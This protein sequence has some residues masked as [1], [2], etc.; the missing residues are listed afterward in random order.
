MTQ[1]ELKTHIEWAVAKK[2]Q[3]KFGDKVRICNSFDDIPD[4]DKDKL[5][6]VKDF[7]PDTGEV[8]C[9]TYKD[10]MA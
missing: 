4:E 5:V 8:E 1:E 6:I 9:E 2:L 7:D 3:N 10:R